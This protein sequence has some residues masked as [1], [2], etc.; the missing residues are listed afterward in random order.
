MLRNWK[1]EKKSVV[2][3]HRC[4]QGDKLSIEIQK[5]ESS[6][7]IFFT[8]SRGPALI[9][10]DSR[11]SRCPPTRTNSHSRTLVKPAIFSLHQCL[12][13]QNPKLY[14]ILSYILLFSGK[15]SPS[16]HLGKEVWCTPLNFIHWLLL[17]EHRKSVEYGVRFC[18]NRHRFGEGASTST[19]SLIWWTTDGEIS[20]CSG[21][22]NRLLPSW[23]IGRMCI[24]GTTWWNT[25]SNFWT[26]TGHG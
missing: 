7:S 23:C 15:Y 21:Q 20:C 18:W 4:L 13:T 19:C 9:F 22:D 11:K 14:P 24:P 8:N 6:L 2:I 1:T 12:L 10:P 26:T 3:Q 5:I 16:M 17:V 25:S